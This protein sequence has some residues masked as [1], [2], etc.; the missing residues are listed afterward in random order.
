MQISRRGALMGAGAA[1]V[2]AG[3]PGAVQAEDVVLL[4]QVAE[5]HELFDRT[6]RSW[7]KHER[8]RKSVEDMPDCPEIDGTLEGNRAHRDFMDAHDAYKGYDRL[9]DL[10]GALA[11]D[12]FETRPVTWRGAVEKFKIA[13]LAVGS[14]AD[15]GDEGL[16]A[17]QCWDSPWMETVAKDFDRLLAGM[18]QGEGAR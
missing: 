13:H 14:Y 8:H 4:A 15:D 1:A 6:K 2:V 11:N 12:I 3:V 5:F 9:W 7:A 10:T 18:R 17:Y 16:E